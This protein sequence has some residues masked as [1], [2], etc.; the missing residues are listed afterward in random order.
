MRI[1]K[2]SGIFLIC[3]LFLSSCKKDE[4]SVKFSIN[5][6]QNEERIVEIENIGDEAS[7]FKMVVNGLDLSDNGNILSFVKSMPSEFDGEPMEMKAFKF[8]RDY[9]WHDDL[10]TKHTWAYSPYLMVNSLGGG[11]CGFRASVL[12]NILKDL[13]FDA[14]ALGL[15]GHVVSEVFT[16]GKWKMLDVDYGVYYFNE[17]GEIASYDELCNNPKLITNPINPVLTESDLKFANCYSA[18]MA[19][20]YYTKDDNVVFYTDYPKELRNIKM[21]LYLPPKAKITCLFNVGLTKNFALLELEL[22]D[23]YTGNIEIPLAIASITGKGEITLGDEK[24]NI[25]NFD[26]ENAVFKNPEWIGRIKVS[27]NHGGIRIYYFINPLVYGFGNQNEI[28]LVGYNVEK[29]KIQKSNRKDIHFRMPYEINF[30]YSLIELKM[31]YVFD[32]LKIDSKQE[33]S[34]D[35]FSKIFFT[36]LKSCESDKKFDDVIDFNKLFL[37]YD[38]LDSLVY[39]LSK[40]T[41]FKF[42]AFLQKDRA[43]QTMWNVFS[44]RAIVKDFLKN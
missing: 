4:K 14:R 28:M 16:D 24:Y 19:S 11:L 31:S 35:E 43:V 15:N 26:A 40:D 38:S 12:T 30:L 34:F 22:P 1:L 42:N 32:S 41:A 27:K 13:G 20:L 23:N 17:R 33:Y 29:L 18:S 5:F 3:V 36:F 25:E 9:T 37:D 10:I 39:A 8:V 44:R 2:C 6:E 7:K 21:Y